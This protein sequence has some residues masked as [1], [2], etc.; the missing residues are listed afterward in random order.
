M[1]RET[2]LQNNILLNTWGVFFYFFCQ[3]VLTIVVTRVSGYEAAGQYSLAVSFTN[4]FSF[5]GMFGMRGL[6]VSDVE[7]KYS[8]GQYYALR[9]VTCAMATVAFAV[10]LPLR[11]YSLP[12]VMSCVAMLAFKLIECVYDVTIG[13]MQRNDQFLYVAVSYTLRGVFPAAA[14]AVV[15]VLGFSL[16]IAIAAMTAVMVLSF[17]IYDLPRLKCCGNGE[18]KLRLSGTVH[19][20]RESF[21]L[22]LTALL[23]AALVY[24][25][26]DAVEK[27]MGSEALGYYS[28]VSIV[29]VVLSTLGTAVWGSV[30]P[31]LSGMFAKGDIL[32]AR[33]VIRIIGV[34][35]ALGAV[36]V[37][38]A[39]NLLGPFFFKLIFGTG[40]LEYMY[41]LTPVLINAVLLL[42]NSFFQCVYIPIKKRSVLMYTNAVAAVV[43]VLFSNLLVKSSGIMG[44]CIGLTIA[45]TVRA[46][47]LTVLC[48]YYLRRLEK[49]G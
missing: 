42:L 29:V 34:S 28:T 32:S 44:A 19:L 41:L 20:L 35:I 3:W 14:F 46:V 48:I 47:L 13:T 26:R 31:R 12:I 33:K 25:P 39:G 49:R 4:I 21:P 22:M 45:L 43:C 36:L 10:T 17:L 7:R 2:N 24:I 15:L 37:L 16:P 30:M 18:N 5:I 40:I 9:M 38:V 23:D 1:K 8:D 6:Q 11:G 27:S